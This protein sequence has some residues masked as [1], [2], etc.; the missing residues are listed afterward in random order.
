MSSLDTKYY[1]ILKGFDFENIIKNT[2]EV[3]IESGIFE[4]QELSDSQKNDDDFFI[5]DDDVMTF[6]DFFIHNRKAYY[7][8]KN[9]LWEMIY[10]KNWQLNAFF[11]SDI[12]HAT[13]EIA[14]L[15]EAEFKQEDKI[16]LIEDS[17]KKYFSLIEDKQYYALYKNKTKTNG[18]ASWEEYFLDEILGH[19]RYEYIS[20]FLKGEVKFLPAALDKNWT[21]Y[22]IFSGI[23]DFC[24]KKKNELLNKPSTMSEENKEKK[25]DMSFRLSLFEVILSSNKFANATANKKG[26]L[27]THLFGDHP[28]NIKHYYLQ[29]E[30]KQN[31]KFKEGGKWAK[32]QAEAEEIVKKIL[33]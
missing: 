32:E 21:D 12:E 29:V 19:E 15:I 18:Y 31:G 26:E 16:K 3:L 14:L 7:L 28:D 6:G 9:V 13:D 1:R 10:V 27:L 17:Y 30:K 8:K 24:E 11:D 4:E 23:S 25:R 5:N 2:F 22:F 20:E 33:G